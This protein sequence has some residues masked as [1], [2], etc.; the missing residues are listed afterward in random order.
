MNAIDALRELVDFIG[1][2]NVPPH[3]LAPI[4]D[5]LWQARENEAQR[6]LELEDA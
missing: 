3:L 6:E 5:V 4:D 2:Q 1:V